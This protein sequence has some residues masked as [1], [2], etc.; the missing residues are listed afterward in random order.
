MSTKGSSL[1][2]LGVAA[3]LFLAVNIVTNRNVGG[4]QLDLTADRLYTLSQ[5]TRNILGN[6]REPITLKLYLSEALANDVPQIKAYA[7]RVRELLHQYASLAKGKIK[8][9]IIAPEPFSDA[10]DQAVRVGVQ[11][12]ALTA[13][14]SGGSLYFGLVGTNTVDDQ[15]VIPFLSS[16][17]EQF[18]EYDLSKLVY[19]LSLATKPVVAVISGLPLEFGT[20][21]MAAAM[22]GRPE[23]YQVLELMRQFFDVRVLN[24]EQKTIDEKVGVLALIHPRNLTTA[25][26]YAI[27]QFVLRG[28]RVLAMVDPHCET[29]GAQLDPLTNRPDPS[30]T[31]GTSLAKLFEAWG[32]EFSDQAF[33]ADLGQAQRVQTGGGG[34]GSGRTVVLYPAWLNIPSAALNKQDIITATLGDIVLASAG[35]ISPRNDATTRFEP[36]LTSSDKAMPMPVARIAGRPEPE[37]LLRDF[38][39]TGQRYTLAA[40]ISGPVKTA[41]PEGAP[42]PAEAKSEE[43]GATPPPPTI[44]AVVQLKQS[45]GAANIIVVGD[46][47]MV[48]DRFWTRTQSLMGQPISLPFAANADFVV[49]AID[50]LA[51]SNDLISLRGR[52]VSQ[53]PFTVVD[54]M[55]REAERQFLARETALKQRLDDT[56]RK[57]AEAQG[58]GSPVAG[59]AGATALLSAEERDA[60]A[61][62][63]SDLLKTRQELRI[64]RRDLSRDIERLES[65][66]KFINIGLGPLAIGLTAVALAVTRRRRRALG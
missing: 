36:L 2:A 51:G 53:R 28:G 4:V 62:F 23:T 26:L 13:D 38:Q 48:D 64:V 32:V 54:G 37:A 22:R 49:N 35:A 14:A 11:G 63:R 19:A 66:V 59:K 10:E 56:A 60:I 31:K 16:D 17:R 46:A 43:A 65:V 27:D 5:G 42:V 30:A 8:L 33:I 12:M 50:N 3:A 40:R 20:G 7:T 39:A 1:I 9:E 21:G 55:R 58:H 6:I 34:S 25:T 47:D 45:V 18:L 61:S 57:L 44:P 15:Q 52:G 29:A 24:G 41:F